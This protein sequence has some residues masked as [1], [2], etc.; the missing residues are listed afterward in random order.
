M[1]T[2]YYITKVKIFNCLFNK[3]DNFRYIFP[4]YKLFHTNIINKI[5]QNK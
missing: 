3:F 4:L 5:C 2:I 1:T